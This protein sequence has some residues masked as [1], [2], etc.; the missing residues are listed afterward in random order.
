M[1]S[2]KCPLCFSENSEH[3]YFQKKFSR[4][5]YRC[6][7]CDLHFVDRSEIV[8]QDEEKARYD[9]HDN[10]K[11]T[12]GYEKFLLRLI[13]PIEENFSY[14]SSGLDFGEGPYPMLRNILNERGFKNISGFDPFYNPKIFSSELTFDFITCCEVLEHVKNPFDTFTRLIYMLKSKG[15]LIVS[16]GVLTSEI[17]FES[18]HYISDITHINIF[19]DKTSKWIADHFDLKTEKRDKDLIVFSK[20]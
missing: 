19:T 3:F 18:W 4:N 12:P 15:A 9:L 16:T 1:D 7:V 14:E 11:R 13:T 20:R 8:S 17:D 6:S 10:S 5:F 2:K